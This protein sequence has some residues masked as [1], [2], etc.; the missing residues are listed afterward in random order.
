MGIRRGFAAWKPVKLRRRTKIW[1]LLAVCLLLCGFVWTW[2]IEFVMPVIFPVE[3]AVDF[4]MIQDFPA[5]I[6]VD[7]LQGY[8]TETQMAE[9][10]TQG[11]RTN[12]S[13]NVYSDIELADMRMEHPGK[14]II[15]IILDRIFG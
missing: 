7:G 5:L 12:L 8:L 4:E 1:I 6:N 11:I 3:E 14:R 2:T 15:R 9:E 13:A 10:I